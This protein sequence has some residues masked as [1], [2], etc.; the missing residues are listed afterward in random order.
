VTATIR[1]DVHERFRAIVARAI[2]RAAR[3]EAEHVAALRAKPMKRIL[4]G[5]ALARA[6]HF[7][8]ASRRF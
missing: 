2:A 6:R 3:E 8:L 7:E 1:A 4:K 5:A